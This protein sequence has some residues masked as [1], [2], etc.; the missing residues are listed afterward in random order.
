MLS[1]YTV[2]CERI[3]LQTSL[4]RKTKFS[5][6]SKE[7][8]LAFLDDENIRWKNVTRFALLVGSSTLGIFKD[9]RKLIQLERNYKSG[10]Y[11]E[12]M[13]NY[14][15]K[16]QSNRVLREEKASV[17]KR[18][19]KKTG[20]AIRNRIDDLLPSNQVNPKKPRL[21]GKTVWNHICRRQV[22]QS[23]PDVI[24]N[25]ILEYS[26]LLNAFTPLDDIQKIWCVNFSKVNELSN[27]DDIE[28]FCGS[29]IILRNYLLLRSKTN[30]DNEDTFV[31]EMLHDLLKEIFRDSNFELVWVNSESTSSKSR[32]C[33]N[34]EN[35]RGKKPDFKLSVN[36]NDEILF[37][38]VKPPKYKNSSLLLVSQD[39]VKLANFQ[40]GTLD[41]LVKKYGNRIGMTSFGVWV[42]GVQIHIYQMDLDYDGLYRMYLIADIVIP[43]QKSQFISLMPI[44]ETFYNVK[45][46]VSKVLEVITSNTSPLPSRSDYCR[47][48]PP[49]PEPI[50]VTVVGGNSN[51]K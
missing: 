40:S 41:E 31:H 7:E 42:Y 2:F 34:K 49:S 6:E 10:Y 19:T 15:E 48:S 5:R 21:T 47:L 1:S 26:K 13:N 39:L 51:R 30:N 36:T 45:D 3:W 32:R 28:K 8:K 43:T 20:K 29:Q 37:G 35:S 9:D 18:L 38:E 4:L 25:I 27:Q 33:N 16:L 46:S 44:L 50:K 24:Q 11:T 17:D 23:L 12:A 14:Y 22:P